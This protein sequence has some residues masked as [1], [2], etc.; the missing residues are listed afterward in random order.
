MLSDRVMDTILTPIYAEMKAQKSQT[1][2]GALKRTITAFVLRGVGGT[3][4]IATLPSSTYWVVV[5]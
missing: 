4:L 5:S 3:C 2:P 1:I